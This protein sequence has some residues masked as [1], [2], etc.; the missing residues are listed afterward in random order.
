M[1]TKYILTIGTT[2]YDVPDE[3]LANWDEISFS[4][5]RTDYSGVMRSYS[6]QF[7]FVGTIRDLLW[8]LFLANGFKAAASVSVYTFTNTHEWE[9]RH[10]AELD[11]SSLEDE[12]GKMTINAIDN[13]LA[14]RLRSMKGQKWEF[15]VDS[16]NTRAVTFKRVDLNNEVKYN[17]PLSD[18]DDGYVNVRIDEAHSTVI[19]T[20]YL[21]PAD[22]SD[23]YDGTSVNR[24]FVKVNRYGATLRIVVQGYVRCYLSPLQYNLGATASVPIASLQFGYWDEDASEFHFW[25]EICNDDITQKRINGTLYNMWIGGAQHKNYTALNLLIADAPSGLYDGMF[26]IVGPNSYG[27]ASY[28]TA[29]QV[30]EYYGGQWRNKGLA[31]QYYQDRFVSASSALPDLDVTQYPMLWLTNDM[32]FI[33]GKMTATWTDP[34]RVEIDADVVTPLQLISKVVD[35]ISPGATVSI[36]NDGAMLLQNT[37][38]VAAEELRKITGAKFYTTF[39][40][41]VDWIGAVF[42]YTYRVVG[43]EVQFVHRSLVFSTEDVK[44]IETFND[45]KLSVDDNLIY[46]EVDAGYSKKDYGEIDG[47][48]ETNFTNYY[49]TGY[50]VTDRKLS[51]ISKY[52]ADKYGVEFTVRKSENE[53]KDDKSDED[54]FTIYAAIGEDQTYVYY[55]SKNTEYSPAVCVTNNAGFIASLGNGAAVTLEMTASD[56]NNPLQDIVIDAGTALFTACEVEFTTNDMDEPEDIN[57]LVQVDRDGYRYSGFISEA[58]SRYGRRNGMEYK[59]IVK[60]ITEL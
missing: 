31:S 10:E 6:T 25:Y 40:Q 16:F 27:N 34:A 44:V 29:N 58:K 46:T 18:N 19:S 1:L 14:A 32:K 60:E 22:E 4:L 48:L 15:P 59:L 45:F 38:L 9:K 11:F 23:G 50:N 57:G 43:N 20:E 41:F 51:L 53:T 17:F 28:W 24:F 37:F 55:P 54:I 2:N 42:G 56:G 13:T 21:E 26:G 3:C 7:V 36:A 49:S 8:S 35:S 30:Y 39:Q 12:E 47:R 5:K 52:R 33:G